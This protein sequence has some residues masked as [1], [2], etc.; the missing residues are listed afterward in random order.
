M[1]TKKGFECLQILSAD[2]S[3]AGHLRGGRDAV[4]RVLDYEGEGRGYRLL[5]TT[6]WFAFR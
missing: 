4:L 3:M 5:E 2:P 6:L 1:D